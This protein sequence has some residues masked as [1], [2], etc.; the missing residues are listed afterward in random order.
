MPLTYAGNSFL[1]GALLGALVGWFACTAVDHW[2]IASFVEQSLGVRL[3]I[4]AAASASLVLPRPLLLKTIFRLRRS[5]FIADEDVQAMLRGRVVG[6]I[7]GIWLG[8]TINSV[9]F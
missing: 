9:L 3:V 4:E 6:V 7:G 2:A 5:V 8:L 1:R